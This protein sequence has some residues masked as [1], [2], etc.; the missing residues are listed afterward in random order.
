MEFIS[1]LIMLENNEIEIINSHEYHVKRIIIYTEFDA[2]IFQ[3]QYHFLKYNL[4]FNAVNVKCGLIKIHT[5][6]VLHIS[7]TLL[8]S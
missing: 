8:L 7:I 6:V 1:Y 3:L 4:M 2:L 5:A